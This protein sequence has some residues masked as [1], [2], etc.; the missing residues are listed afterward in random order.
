MQRNASYSVCV[1][2]VFF[3]PEPCKCLKENLILYIGETDLRELDGLWTQE[4]R[5]QVFS[6]CP[7]WSQLPDCRINSLD[8][9]S[10]KE[11]LS[12]F[13]ACSQVK[14]GAD[15]TSKHF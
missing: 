11:A 13:F 7:P 4:A 14:T 6:P 1:N 5:S 10:L 12:N 3:T 8:E 15:D 2:S 9:K